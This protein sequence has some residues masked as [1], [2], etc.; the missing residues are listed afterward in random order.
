MDETTMLMLAPV[1]AIDVLM[2]IVAL[3]SLYRARSTRHMPKAAWA[4]VIVIV[5]LVG[6]GAWFLAG[7]PEEE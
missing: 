5:T 3:V 4:A 6:W 2:R 1:V 7:R